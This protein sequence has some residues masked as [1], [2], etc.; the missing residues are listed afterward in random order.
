MCTEYNQDQNTYRFCIIKIGKQ[1]K[2]LLFQDICNFTRTNSRAQLGVLINKKTFHGLCS[3]LDLFK[4]NNVGIWFCKTLCILE[5]FVK[6]SFGGFH[7]FFMAIKTQFY[8]LI[9]YHW[10]R[11]QTQLEAFPWT[12]F[13]KPKLLIR[14]SRNYLICLTI[15]RPLANTEG[16]EHKFTIGFSNKRWCLCSIGVVTYA[17]YGAGANNRIWVFYTVL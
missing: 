7:V 8:Q 4:Q 5:N 12:G 10:S 13:V 17:Q 9:Q 16:T 1:K 2:L 3:L 11:T 15:Q 6:K 14:V